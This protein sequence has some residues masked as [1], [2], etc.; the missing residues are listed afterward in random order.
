VISAPVT[1]ATHRSRG[2]MHSE[3]AVLL[4]GTSETR[5]SDYFLT[6]MNA[7]RAPQTIA[8]INMTIA[9][10][11]LAHSHND[12]LREIFRGSAI[13][14]ASPRGSG[15]EAAAAHAAIDGIGARI[16]AARIPARQRA[17]ETRDIMVL[18]EPRQPL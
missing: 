13:V 17:E 2:A 9:Y 10:S 14:A 7:S 12:W 15:T 11:K 16:H 8:N 6:L 4:A 3:S 5:W 1:V 18:A